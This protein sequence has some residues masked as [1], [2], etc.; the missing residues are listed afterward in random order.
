MKVKSVVKII[1]FILVLAAAILIFQDRLIFFPAAWPEGYVLPEELDNA[2]LKSIK[3]STADQLELDAV[4]ASARNTAAPNKKVILYSHGNAGNLLN[5]L[6]RVDMLCS[7][8]FDVLIYDYR[9]F[10][11]S[12]GKANVA[13]AIRDGRAALAYLTDNKGFAPSDIIIYGVSLGTGIAAELV[14]EASADFAG[15]VLESGFA[16]LGAQASKKFPFVGSLILKQDLPTLD[17]IKSYKGRLLLIHS[18]NDGII[19]YADSE[20]LFAAS[21][22]D[23]KQF[24]TLEGVGHNSPVWNLDEYKTAWQN[25]TEEMKSGKG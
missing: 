5:R 21:P 23:T 10:G 14:K 9:G 11:R 20:K 15:V 16:S 1:F 3:I 4:Y 17:T 13:G 25:F 19:S 22:S 18:K 7:L 12:E 2:T 24:L 8:G 6:E